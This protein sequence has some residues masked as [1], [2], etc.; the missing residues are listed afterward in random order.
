M[1]MMAT[2]HRFVDD[3]KTD[4]LPYDLA[5]AS[6]C[7]ARVLI[8]GGPGADVHAVAASI[9]RAG[10]RAHAPFLTVRCGGIEDGVLEGKLFG[11]TRVDATGVVRHTRG[12]L[13]RADGGTLLLT[14][15]GDLSPRLQTRLL[16]FLDTRE[17]RRAG[18]DCAHTR[19]DVRLIA[20]A[21]PGL[22]EE[23]LSARFREDLFYR[24]NTLHLLV[25]VA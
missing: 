10:R 22:F 2:E 17:V 24:L 14:D 12:C 23:T 5:H 19:V 11:R 3:N 9:H 15:V 16:Q 4:D 18:A 25:G 20:S 1:T 13:E 21:A 8:S 6:R 7:D